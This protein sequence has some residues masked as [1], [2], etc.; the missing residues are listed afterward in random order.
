MNKSIFTN[1]VYEISTDRDPSYLEE[2]GYKVG[3]RSS[4]KLADRYLI[5]ALEIIKFICKEYWTWLF[6]KQIDNLK[7]NHRGVYVISDYDFTFSLGYTCGL[8]RGALSNFGMQAYV[9]AEI[10]NETQC[11]F[12]IKIV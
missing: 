10:S 8:I 4:L 12:Q 9:S 5:D 1:L 2:L 6:N 7:T 3:K 11:S